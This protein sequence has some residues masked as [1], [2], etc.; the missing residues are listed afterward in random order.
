MPS[1]ERRTCPSYLTPTLSKMKNVH[2][3]FSF[4]EMTRLTHSYILLTYFPMLSL[5]F[6]STPSL[7]QL[8]LYPSHSPFPFCSSSCP[9]PLL[10]I[11]FLHSPDRLYSTILIPPP[12]PT[13]PFLSSS[14]NPSPT[15]SPSRVFPHPSPN[16]RCSRFVSPSFYPSSPIYH[17]FLPLYI[18]PLSISLSLYFSISHFLNFICPSLYFSYSSYPP[19]YPNHPSLSSSPSLDHSI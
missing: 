5:F 13:C 2:S 1:K 15:P 18:A 8:L 17:Y 3:C 10:F 4:V 16:L 7:F 9:F 14:L 19:P 11:L 6:C 12:S